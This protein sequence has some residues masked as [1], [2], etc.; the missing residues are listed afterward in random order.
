MI[1]EKPIM[2]NYGY[3]S[4]AGFHDEPSGWL[5]EGGEDAYY[6]ALKK[7]ERESCPNCSIKLSKGYVSDATA[8]NVL[9][10]FKFEYCNECMYIGDSNITNISH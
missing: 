10:S 2:E 9:V 8:G 7:W 4:Q 3:H 6:E 1:M 5:L